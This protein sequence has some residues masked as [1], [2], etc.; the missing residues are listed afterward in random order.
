[1]LLAEYFGADPAAVL[2]EVG[3]SALDAAPPEAR[4]EAAEL[5]RRLY[6]L[7]AADRA[8]ILKQVN[9][10]LEF[11]QAP[12]DAGAARAARGVSPR[13]VRRRDARARR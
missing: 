10:I 9:E 11:L 2:A 8:A 12:S 4:A 5:L 7:P 6:A 3:L 1:M 13:A